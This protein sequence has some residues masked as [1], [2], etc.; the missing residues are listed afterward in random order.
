MFDD[1]EAGVLIV[2]VGRALRWLRGRGCA[3]GVGSGRRRGREE[4]DALKGLGV[5]RGTGGGGDVFGRVAHED[6]REVCYIL[7][8]EAREPQWENKHPHRSPHTLSGT[9]KPLSP[10]APSHQLLALLEG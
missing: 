6:E 1:A 10:S 3:Q 7:D 4:A 8:E 9:S 5:E 2:S